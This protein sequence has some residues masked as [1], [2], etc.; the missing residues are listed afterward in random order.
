MN[1]K[2]DQ[3]NKINMIDLNQ[4]QLAKKIIQVCLCSWTMSTVAQGLV[5]NLIPAYQSGVKT[6]NWFEDMMGSTSFSVQLRLNKWQEK[7]WGD[8]RGWRWIAT[9]SIRL[10]RYTGGYRYETYIRQW[11]NSVEQDEVFVLNMFDLESINRLNFKCDQ[12]DYGYTGNWANQNKVEDFDIAVNA[13]N[14]SQ[15]GMFSSSGPFDA[16]ASFNAT[17]I[18]NNCFSVNPVTL[19]SIVRLSVDLK[20]T[21]ICKPSWVNYRYDWPPNI[22]IRDVVYS[23]GNNK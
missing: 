15:S 3:L 1:L 17:Q 11:V 8:L 12:S 6:F 19:N 9:R 22:N 21:T 5:Q 18:Q 20:S 14:V 2:N 10:N 4:K 23:F 7:N 13:V 16:W